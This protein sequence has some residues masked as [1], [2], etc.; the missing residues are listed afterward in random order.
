MS[1]EIFE[2]FAPR[3]ARRR[4]TMGSALGHFD[5]RSI[6]IVETGCAYNPGDWDG[7]GLSTVVFGAWAAVT[8]SHL[9]SVDIDPD[10]LASAR[11]LASGP[12]T[13]V[14]DDSVHYLTGR[15]EPIDLLYLDSLDYPYGELLDLYGGKE[16]LPAAIRR[17]GQMGEAEV[18]RLH[19]DIIAA[20]QEHCA[21]E[22]TAALPLLAEDSVVLI[23]DAAL[24]GG[25]KARLAKRLLAEMDWRLVIEGY[26]SLWSRR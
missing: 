26:Q 16:D 2:A 4:T 11:Q 13:Y 17:L 7:A 23:D 3:L 21:R 19:G 22:L 24:P 10:H 6:E 9:T 12:I 25:G 18:V 1:W 20:S 14:L 15:T 5:P 8:G